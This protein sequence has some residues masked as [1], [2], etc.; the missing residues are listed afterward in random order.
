[1]NA[2]TGSNTLRHPVLQHSEGP[3]YDAR[4]L[5]GSESTARIVL[6]GKVYTLRITKAGKLILTK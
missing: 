1:M 2:L 5:V 3:I 4:T 6:D